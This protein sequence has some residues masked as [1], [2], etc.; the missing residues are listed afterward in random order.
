MISKKIELI[1]ETMKV[2]LQLL[3]DKSHTRGL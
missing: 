2:Y 1:S 3:T